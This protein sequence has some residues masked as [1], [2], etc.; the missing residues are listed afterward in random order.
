[1]RQRLFTLLYPILRALWSYRYLIVLPMLIM[2]LV[3]TAVGFLGTKSYRS[4]TTILVQETG[5]MNPFL[6]DLSIAINLK[7]RMAALRV[8][9]HSRL[10]L[11]EVI[12]QLELA[13]AENE[14]AVS[15]MREKLSA[16]IKVNLA[17]SDLIEITITWQNP[18]QIVPILTSVS[19]IF[20]EKLKAPGRTSVESSERFLLQQLTQTQL[21]L[22]Y[23]EQ[24]LSSFKQTH[25]DVLPQL[26]GTNAVSITYLENQL[27]ETDLALLQA[28]ASKDALKNRLIKTNP[29]MALL[30]E[31]LI[32][33]EAQLTIL[34]ARYTDNH[35][36]VKAVLRRVDTLRNE[37]RRLLE[38]QNNL[39]EDELNQLWTLAA[40]ISDDAG[41]ASPLLA[42]QLEQYQRAETQ[43]EQLQQKQTLLAKQIDELA[44]RRVEMAKLENELKTLERDFSVK[45]SI[46]NRLLERYEMAQVTGQLGRFEEED[47]LRI[48]DLPFVPTQPTAWP[49]WMNFVLGLFAGA[50]LGLSLCTV[51]VL[52]DTRVYSSEQIRQLTQAPILGRIRNSAPGAIV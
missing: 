19:T 17:G 38:E 39:T 15:I 40:N 50:G 18:E 26:Q 14:S 32:K 44:N 42:S 8:M 24:Q 36:E 43:V 35:S 16:A 31:E 30:E 13:P 23:A 51:F 12:E 28:I 9:L 45:E 7:E 1:M 47:K 10:V 41:K 6:E 21:D 52:L 11:N 25:I 33:A 29:V 27:R 3:L 5:L 34:R 48:I 2:P 20:I 49:W 22:E 37:S 4:H 46:Y